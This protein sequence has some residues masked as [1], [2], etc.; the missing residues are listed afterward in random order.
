MQIKKADFIGSYPN[1]KLCP[2]P[3]YPEY[4]F[5]GRS[6]VGKSSLIN[7]LCGRKNLAHTSGK[8]G[9]TQTINTFIVNNNWYLSDLPGYGFARASA[10]QRHK[11]KKMIPDYLLYRP[12]LQCAFLLIDSCVSPQKIDLEFA[13]WMG[14]NQIPFIIVFTKTD[15][16][17]SKKNKGFVKEFQ[18]KILE[19]W[20]VMPPYYLS[21][22]ET[23]VGRDNILGLIHETNQRFTKIV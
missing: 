10:M 12:N 2:P 11:W 15:R 21:S 3:K 4:A 13:D 7:M 8:P 22:A 19:N 20:E 5:I 16:K 9:K 23:Q 1:Y 14:E 18:A 6:N 17:K